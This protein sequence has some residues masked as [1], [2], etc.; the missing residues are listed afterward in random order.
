[1]ASYGTH[2][3]EELTA[4]LRQGNHAAYTELFNRYWS[5][6]YL[7]ARKML[8]DEDEAM[9]V[10]QDIFTLLW[11]RSA[12]ME[13]S[14]SVK[15]YLYTA[16]R[17][18]VLKIISRGKLKEKFIGN[19]TKVMT[20]LVSTTENQVD[21]NELERLIEREIAS[22]PPQMQRI[23]NKSRNEGLSYKEIATELGITEHTVKTTIYRAVSILRTKIAGVLSLLLIMGKL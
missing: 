18:Q 20:E 6:M 17:N 7:H 10:V 11:T 3:D 14:V 22:L 23:Y 15:S 12:E 19:M 4:L 16:V 21:Y 1:M 9:D 8:H 2:T 5:A 13:F